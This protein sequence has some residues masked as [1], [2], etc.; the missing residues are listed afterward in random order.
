[1]KVV[2]IRQS[3]RVERC[4]KFIF[5]LVF[6]IS[7]HVVCFDFLKYKWGLLLFQTAVVEFNEGG[8]NKTIREG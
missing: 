7:V 5:F 1:M 2:S 6:L 4:F 8:L 3:E